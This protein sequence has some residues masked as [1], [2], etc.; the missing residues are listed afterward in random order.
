MEL[1][2]ENNLVKEARRSINGSIMLMAFILLAGLVINIAASVIIQYIQIEKNVRQMLSENIEAASSMVDSGLQNLKILVNDHAYDYEFIAGSATQKT[3]HL[4]LISSFDENVIGMSYID[5]SGNVY[6]DAVPS[7]VTNLLNSKSQV[8]T[9]PTDESSDFYMAVKTDFGS[10]VSHMKAAKLKTIING[11]ACDVFILSSDGTVIASETKYG[12]YD[13]KYTSYV[14]KSGG[15]TVDV[16]ARKYNGVRYVYASEYIEGSDDWTIM[17]KAKSGNYYSGAVVAFWVNVVLLIAMSFLGF[18]AV[19]LIKSKM[20]KPLEQIRRKIVDM[21]QGNLSGEP[22]KPAQNLELGGLAVAVNELSTINKDIITDIGRTADAIAHENLAVHT[23]TEYNGDFLPVR[24][25]LESIIDSIRKVVINVETAAGKVSESSSQMSANSA[26]L[27]QAAAEEATTVTELNESLNG[28]HELINDNMDKTTKALMASESAERSMEEG[29]AKMANMLAAMNEINESSSEIANIIKAIQDISF[30]TNILALNASIEAARA[31]EAGKGFAVVAEEVSSLADKTSEAAKST[32]KLI[33]NSL[34]SVEHGTV[35]A[36]ESAAVLGEIA[37][38]A[39]ISA[40]VV[41]EIAETASKQTDAINL[42]LEGMNRIS[43]SVNQ[44]NNSA[45]EC[46][47]SSNVL[48]EESTMLRETIDGFILDSNRPAQRAP[49]RTSSATITLPGDEPKSTPAPKTAAPKPAPAPKAAASK[50]APA[51]KTE[52]PK[53]AYTPK[54]EAPKSAA[55]P[56]IKTI[57]LPDDEPKSAPAA[58]SAPSFK[59]AAPAKTAKP[60]APSAPAPKPAPAAK[61]PTINLDDG[62]DIAPSASAG[63]PISKA[64]MQP[65]KRTIR[66][67]NDKY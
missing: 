8:L 36:N 9:S 57:T 2:A 22:L 21:S 67:D 19:A 10:L 59:A 1:K 27:S 43:T 41:K 50:P 20:I 5:A 56:A 28:V 65:V 16:K 31:G 53:P 42:V 30:Q 34:K 66:L 48:A 46:A 37:K 32:T 62:D 29:N 35:I 44:I 38:Q 33:E 45:S 13:S 61:R 17:I 51:P 15:S 25:A 4:E 39:Q 7:T 24:D 26:I 18:L 3:E 63:A 6:G 23:S 14:Q 47:D 12:A 58:K 40:E 52:A 11:S 54:T 49:K 55:K 60:A 64:T